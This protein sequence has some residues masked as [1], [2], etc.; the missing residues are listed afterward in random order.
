MY[1]VF[2]HATRRKT[3]SSI[4][5]ESVSESLQTRVNLIKCRWGQCSRSIALTKDAE[6]IGLIS[7]PTVS[8]VQTCSWSIHFEFHSPLH[9]PTPVVKH[10]TRANTGN[11]MPCETAR[12]CL[13]VEFT[14]LRGASGSTYQLRSV[15]SSTNF[16]IR[17]THTWVTYNLFYVCVHWLIT[18]VHNHTN[19]GSLL[20][21]SS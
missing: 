9:L 15:H 3:I 18:V 5:D 2:R 1:I 19:E 17:T 21:I 11:R 6:S 8:A 13:I 7:E 12:R 20:L 14:F 16:K 4:S 10:E